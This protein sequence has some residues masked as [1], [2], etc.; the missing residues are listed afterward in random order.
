MLFTNVLLIMSFIV[1][2]VSRGNISKTLV[3]ETYF[4]FEEKR[5][6]IIAFN[7]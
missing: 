4:L 1:Y 7:A 2:F 3:P 5:D 6:V